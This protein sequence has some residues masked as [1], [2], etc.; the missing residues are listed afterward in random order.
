MV[1]L[2][3]I[4]NL[5]VGGRTIKIK[6]EDGYNSFLR[7]NSPIIDAIGNVGVKEINAGN[8]YL[9]LSLVKEDIDKMMED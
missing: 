2:K 6:E 1:T 8:D 7:T 3:E 9:I 4:V 5:Y